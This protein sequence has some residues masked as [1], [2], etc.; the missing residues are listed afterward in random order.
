[1]V[2]TATKCLLCIALWSVGCS[3]GSAPRPAT[4]PSGS[5]APAA[6]VH[7]YEGRRYLVIELSDGR[8]Y[9]I[10]A[11]TSEGDVIRPCECD[12]KECKPMCGEPPPD[13][14]A[15]DAGTSTP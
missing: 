3:G 7:T 9:A 5:E 6:R 10:P 1:M 13:A 8:S 11:D 12:L 2:R 4:P 15:P 14:A